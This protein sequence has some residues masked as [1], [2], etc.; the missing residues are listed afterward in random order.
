[1]S[2][3][4][5]FTDAGLLPEGIHQATWDEVVSRFGYNV[6]RHRLLRG[7]R[8]ALGLLREAG[9]LRIYLDGSFVTAKKLPR[10]FDACWD[11]EGVDFDV[12]DAVFLDFSYERAAQKRR[13]GG[14]FFPSQLIEESTEKPFLEFFQ[15]DRET[16]LPKGIIEIVLREK[17]DDQKRASVQGHEGPGREIRGSPGAGS[18]G[19]S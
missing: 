4:P 12:L 17:R 16:G 14:E 7:L 15:T 11:E 5:D 1:M 13:F 19:T 3:I 9:C 2:V 18:R 6:R 8:A 10:D